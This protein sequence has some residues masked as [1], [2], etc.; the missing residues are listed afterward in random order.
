[1]ATG[2]PVVRKSFDLD[3]LAAKVLDDAVGLGI[4][5]NVTEA[6]HV[7]IDLLRGHVEMKKEKK[8]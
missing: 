6:V 5:S 1:M 8:S 4:A 2:K 7:A 3:P